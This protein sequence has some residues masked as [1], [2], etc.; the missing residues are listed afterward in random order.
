MNFI[1]WLVVNFLGVQVAL[2]SFGKIRIK[3]PNKFPSWIQLHRDSDG[4]YFQVS[5]MNKTPFMKVYDWIQ[6]GHLS[7]ITYH[8][9]NIDGREW[10][11]YYIFAMFLSTIGFG[12]LSQ[13]KQIGQITLTWNCLKNLTK[14]DK[15]YLGIVANSLILLMGY[16]FYLAYLTNICVEYSLSFV[17]IVSAYTL[18]YQFWLKDT[19]TGQF[20]VHHWF[21]GW[22]FSLFFRFDTPISKLAC[23]ILYGIFLQGATAFNVTII[24]T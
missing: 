19:Q 8:Y 16:H 11:I 2:Y 20:H 23:M 17:S 15:I 1:V 22:F 5:F 13:V 4:F 21:C 12:I 3:N 24:I 9:A 6:I 7:T 18:L 10:S 14:Y